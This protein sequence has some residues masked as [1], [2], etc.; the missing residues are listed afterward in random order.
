MAQESKVQL[1]KG[2]LTDIRSR[3]LLENDCISLKALF[4]MFSRD[5][6]KLIVSEESESPWLT[7][8]WPLY[9]LFLV[10]LWQ[11]EGC[12]CL[13]TS[14]TLPISPWISFLTTAHAV[15]TAGTIKYAPCKPPRT[16]WRVSPS[17]ENLSFLSCRGAC[18]ICDYCCYSLQDDGGGQ[19][20]AAVTEVPFSLEDLD[21]TI[22]AFDTVEQLLR[23]LSP[24]TWKQDLDS[25]YTQTHIHYRS[26]AYHL[27][28]RHNKGK[29]SNFYKP[30]LTNVHHLKHMYYNHTVFQDCRGKKNKKHR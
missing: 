30:E 20:P 16:L 5:L 18:P 19:M 29:I 3:H 25:I 1:K 8:L 24:D 12:W 7:G 15:I 13:L 10:S 23:S 26:R 4:E 22:A 9:S 14:L 21:R 28:S 2:M 11:F 6:W 17:S 27:A